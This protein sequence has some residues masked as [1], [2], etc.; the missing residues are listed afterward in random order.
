MSI[1]VKVLTRPTSDAS[2]VR[3]MLSGMALTFKH[4]MNPHKKTEQ[5]PEG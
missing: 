1:Q 5:Y 4:M 2:Y 3:A